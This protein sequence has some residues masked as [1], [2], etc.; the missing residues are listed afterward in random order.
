MKIVLSG[1]EICNAYNE[2]M[3]LEEINSEFL[4]AILFR[5]SGQAKKFK[6]LPKIGEQ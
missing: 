1:G 2:E 5:H 4:K 6:S 3:E